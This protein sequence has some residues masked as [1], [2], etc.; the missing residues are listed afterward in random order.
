MTT[1]SAW[2]DERKK[3]LTATD[4]SAILGKNPYRSAYM[5]W[6][7]KTGR[8]DDKLESTWPMRRG[9][10]MEG[11]APEEYTRATGR[12]LTLPELL[13]R[14]TFHAC[15]L[16]E[17]DHYGT[18]KYLARSKEHPWLMATPDLGCTEWKPV[19]HDESETE[20]LEVEGKP[21]LVEVKTA[22]DF[23]APRFRERDYPATHIC[24]LQQGLLVTGLEWGS[25]EVLFWTQDPHIADFRA[26]KVLHQIMLEQLGK[27]WE[28]NVLG[29]TPPAE[30]DGSKETAAVLLSGMTDEAALV[31]DSEEAWQIHQAL[32]EADRRRAEFAK[33]EKGVQSEIQWHKNRLL[34]IM[35]AH[36]VLNLKDP[37]GD[38]EGHYKIKV[39][40]AKAQPAKPATSSEYFDSYKPSAK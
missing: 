38:E 36:R 1:T 32:A 40:K 5:V 23:T 9:L 35:G 26:N 18:A 14:D 12:E 17:L 10:H 34:G 11:A 20:F 13:P 21:G 6:A 8:A 15:D 16:L 31:T 28:K 29:D 19:W 24:Q 27:F 25:L 22:Q 4:C 39:R 3:G 7:E 2:L 33:M 37:S 30:I